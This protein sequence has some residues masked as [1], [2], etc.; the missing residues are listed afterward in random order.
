MTPATSII[1]QKHSVFTKR[2]KIL[3]DFGHF[4]FRTTFCNPLIV[5]TCCDISS[6]H[7]GAAEESNQ[8]GYTLCLFFWFVTPF[9]F[10]QVA[11]CASFSGLP[12]RKFF[13][14]EKLCQFFC[15][16]IVYLFF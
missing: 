9:H 4:F 8:L 5:P 13:W 15:V 10:L 12:V 16:V 11:K 2:P 14:V 1:K 7:S 6:Y 3:F